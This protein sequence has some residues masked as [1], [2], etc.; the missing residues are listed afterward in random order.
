MHVTA[1]RRTVLAALGAWGVVSVAGV[2]RAQTDGAGVPAGLTFDNIDGGSL[3]LDQ[4]AGRP[5]LVVNTASLCGFAKQFIGL[6]DL[7]DRYAAQGLVV[8]AVP[9]DDFN[10]ELDG[11][12]AVKEYCE[13]TFGIDLPMTGIT[14]VKGRQ[15]HPFYRW[16]AQEH[17]VRP[18]WNFHKVLIGRDGRFVRDW[19][20]QVRPDAASIVRAIE[21]ELQTV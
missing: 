11:E 3:A 5:I 2:A 10:Q 18:R 9:S 12:S 7:Q 16:L 6:Q 8:L 20:S 4:W 21:T 19:R 15:A 1:S 17:G 14:R 13:M